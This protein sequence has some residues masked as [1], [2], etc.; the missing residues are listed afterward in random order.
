MLQGK[1]PTLRILYGP[2]G[3]G[4]TWQAARDAVRLVEPTISPENVVAA[5]KKYIATGQIIWVTF[6]PSYSY[7]DFV[8]G[9]RPE[10]TEHG[11]NFIPR[12]GPFRIACS[13]VNQAPPPSQQFVFGQTLTSSTGQKYRITSASI[14]S[15]VVE[16]IGE[17]KGSGLLTPV[18]L[19][20]ITRLQELGYKPG[21][22]SLP[23]AKHEEKSQIA[24]RVGYDKQTLFGMTGPLRAV[25]E[26][27]DDQQLEPASRRPVV[28]VIDEINRA[29]LSRVFGEL[30]TLLE[31]DK[32]IGCPEERKVL[33]PYSLINFGVP[34]E[35]HII[36]TMN[37][38]DRS[39][40]TMD[41]ALRRRFDFIEVGPRATRAASPYA[42]LDLPAVLER[43][44]SSIQAIASRDVAIGHAYLEQS[45]LDRVREKYELSPNQEGEL[46]AFSA[47]LREAIIPLLLD[48]FHGEWRKV[49]FVLGRDFSK[50]SESLL[51]TTMPDELLA[52]AGELIDIENDTYFEL[53]TWWDPQSNNWNSERFKRFFI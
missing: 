20:V 45:N 52:R 33:L 36:G 15:V 44:N 13:N 21:D 37:T 50:P 4:K 22:L 48:M 42:G 34:N 32:R 3:T 29:D 41:K 19:H 40:S 35:L 2:P 6:H 18:S 26:Y 11:I 23:G 43:W 9:F 5:H 39:I 10:V 31:S 25:W 38:A 7:E 27:V 53:A 12:P 8:E 30:I 14:D 28:L 51:E 16:N 49:D 46:K 17:G 24:E 47:V 1:N